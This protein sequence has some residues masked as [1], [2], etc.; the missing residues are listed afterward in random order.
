MKISGS[1]ENQPPV[2]DFTWQPAIPR[3]GETIQFIDRSRD[4]DGTIV[5]WNWYRPPTSAIASRFK[6]PSWTYDTPGTYEVFLVVKDNDGAAGATQRYI[7]VHEQEGGSRFGCIDGYVRDS[8]S[9]NALSGARVEMVQGP[10]VSEAMTNSQGYFKLCNLKYGSYSLAARKDGY[11]LLGPTYATVDG[12]NSCSNCENVTIYMEPIGAK[13]DLVVVDV[14]W[15]PQQPTSSDTLAVTVKVKNQG[16]GSSGGFT[17]A[18]YVG[19][20]Q[21]GSTWIGKGLLPGTTV[22]VK[23]QGD[24]SKWTWLTVCDRSHTI[25]A[26]VDETNNDWES[27]ESNNERKE[28]IHIA[29]AEKPDL[30]VTDIT[31]IPTQPTEEDTITINVRIK[32]QG[33]KEAGSFY[34]ALYADGTYLEKR[35]LSRLAAGATSTIAYTGAASKWSWMKQCGKNHTL[36]AIADY[37]RKVDESNEANNELSKSICIAC[38]EESSGSLTGSRFSATCALDGRIKVTLSYD[39]H[40][41]EKAQILFIFEKQATGEIVA[42]EVVEVDQGTGTAE[43]YFDCPSNISG[44]YQVSWKA[45]KKCDTTS[46]L[47][48]DCPLWSCARILAQAALRAAIVRYDSNGDGKISDSER[49]NAYYDYFKYALITKDELCSVTIFNDYNCQPVAWS[50]P[51][52]EQEVTCPCGGEDKL[53]DLVVEDIYW[54][55]THP[56]EEDSLGLYIKLWNKGSQDAG[57]FYVSLKVDG[58]F[59]TEKRLDGLSSGKRTT[60]MISEGSSDWSWKHECEVTHTL[61]AIADAHHEIAESNEGNNVLEKTIEIECAQPSGSFTAKSFEAYCIETGPYENHINC[62]LSYDN[63]LNESAWIRFTFKKASTGEI[64]GQARPYANEGSGGAG[65]LFECPPDAPGTY[66]LSWKVYRASDIHEQ[67]PVAWCESSE[68]LE[69][70]CPCGGAGEELFDRATTNVN[71]EATLTISNVRIDVTAQIQLTSA[72]VKGVQVLKSTS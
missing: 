69:V 54:R 44:V 47:P 56:T 30:A 58:E 32:N 7:T 48:F 26:V 34:T 27:D 6:N 60:L 59:F 10:T 45:Y 64:I 55:P 62:T 43:V 15:T 13:S 12:P 24:S 2:A 72:T 39:N 63:D 42:H 52:D 5:E 22:D 46:L 4:P 25:R 38:S 53:P 8:I 37:D 1:G 70:S 71:G 11:N 14:A 17:V 31:W 29:C 61:K 36:K 66:R 68:E 18:A 3:A 33:S 21:L 65:A 23:F 41:G 35:Y 50:E 16:V 40:L 28:T 49:Q 57:R 9:R 20:A 19:T 67:N 51:T